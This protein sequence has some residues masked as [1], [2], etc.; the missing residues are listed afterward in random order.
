MTS[1]L[2]PEAVGSEQLTEA[3]R[4]S[5]VIGGARVSDVAVVSSRS[6]ILSHIIRLRLAYEGLAPEAPCTVIFKNRTPR[7]R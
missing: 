6:T 4:R 3:F 1:E 5:G 7:P 2:L